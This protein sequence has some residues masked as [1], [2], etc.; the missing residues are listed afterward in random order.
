MAGTAVGGADVGRSGRICKRGRRCG[1]VSEDP[2]GG[3]SGEGVWE[4]RGSPGH[5]P[6]PQLLEEQCLRKARLSNTSYS[7]AP[8]VFPGCSLN[9]WIH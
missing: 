5:V 9:T 3:R 7:E 2:R 8:Y 6:V 1:A 4:F